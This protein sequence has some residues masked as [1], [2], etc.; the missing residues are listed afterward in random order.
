MLSGRDGRARYDA[1]MLSL[2]LLRHGKSDWGADFQGDHERPLKKRGIKAAKRMGDL[3]TSAGNAPDV[4]LTSSAVR[5]RTTAELAHEA[6]AWDCA[7]G[8]EGGLYDATPNELLEPVR[9]HGA[10]E[11]VLVVNHEPTC[12]GAVATLCGGAPPVFPTAAARRA[13]EAAN[14][15]DQC[16]EALRAP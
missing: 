13:T 7:I 16:K 6:G 3:L 15:Q 10:G 5:A 14:Q 4:V 9:E 11:R 12:S 2:F 8:V 1:L